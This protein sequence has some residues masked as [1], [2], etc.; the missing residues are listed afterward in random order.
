MRPKT[1]LTLRRDSGIVLYV[2]QST[3]G[4]L[5]YASLRHGAAW[6]ADAI[7]APGDDTFICGEPG[8]LA[9][10]VKDALFHVHDAE[11][12]RILDAFPSIRQIPPSTAECSRSTCAPEGAAL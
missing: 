4:G 11:A 8:V 6:L 3:A 1:E 7:A 10:S 2:S 5:I 12:A 9:L